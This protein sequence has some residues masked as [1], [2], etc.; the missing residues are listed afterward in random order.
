M[1]LFDFVKAAGAALGI[2][3]ADESPKA[4][5]V[6]KEL[7]KQGL[8][9]KDVEIE[10]EGDKVKIKGEAVSQEAKEKAILTVGN[11]LGVASVEEDIKTGDG[12][13]QAVFHTVEKATRFG[14][15]PRSIS[16]AATNTP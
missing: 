8:D 9:V 11:L 5:A 15:S 2:T 6:K 12:A 7:E 4:E 10:V 3:S 1:G 13:D 16:A 14:R